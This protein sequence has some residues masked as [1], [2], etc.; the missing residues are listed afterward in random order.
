MTEPPPELYETVLRQCAAAQPEPW[1]P[2]PFAETAGVSR[3]ALDAALERL[4]LRGLVHLTPWTPGHGQGYALTPD[5]ERVLRDAGLLTRVRAGSVPAA[6]ERDDDAPRRPDRG[7]TPYERGEAVR[8]ALLDNTRP[9]VIT[10]V[11]IGI[12]VAVFLVELALSVRQNVKLEDCAFWMDPTVLH[13][14]G[15]VDFYDILRGEWWRLLSS[16]FVHIGYLHIGVNMYALYNIGPLIERLLGRWRY[17]LLYLVAGFG[18]SCVGVIGQFGCAGASGA[19]CGLLGALAAWTFLNRQFLPPPLLAS[20]QRYLVV[21]TFLIVAISFWGRVSWSGHLGGAVFGLVAAA[22]LNWQRFGSRPV[23]WLALLAVL[24]LP[25]AGVAG[26]RYAEGKVPHLRDGREH[27]EIEHFNAF[28]KEQFNP[29]LSDAVR[30][31]TKEV[32]PLLQR[33]AR[34]RDPDAVAQALAALDEG[35]A[36]LREASAGLAKVGPFAS[37]H[38]AHIQQVGTDYLAE[39]VAL[40]DVSERCLRAGADGTKKDDQQLQEQ[41]KRVDEATRR[42]SDALSGK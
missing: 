41:D 24:A 4:R 30:R 3:D 8:E 26:M 2:R 7:A 9:P 12:N 13:Q 36:K 6:L 19:I 1:Y 31:Y 15:S 17:L 34:R 39:W 11:L 14:T 25:L 23:R 29:L 21:N 27:V 33:N 10:F 40:Y 22:L 20:I 37:A 5:G 42:W 18:G 28:L 38:L 32:E 16:C 35:R